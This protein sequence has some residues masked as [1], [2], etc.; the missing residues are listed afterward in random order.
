MSPVIGTHRQK[1]EKMKR[2]QCH[3]GF[4]STSNNRRTFPY[5]VRVHFTIYS[6]TSRHTYLWTWV[7][8]ETIQKFDSKMFGCAY[9]TRREEFA[10]IEKCIEIHF[11]SNEMEGKSDS[12]RISN[13]YTTI[14]FSEF[15]LLFTQME[16]AP[17]PKSSSTH[18]VQHSHH[19]RIIPYTTYN[20]R[21]RHGHN[22][23]TNTGA[24]QASANTETS[25]HKDRCQVIITITEQWTSVGKLFGCCA[26]FYFALTS[27]Y[28]SYSHICSCFRSRRNGRRK[29]RL[30]ICDVDRAFQFEN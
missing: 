30:R 18:S 25:Q 22:A 11:D 21:M 3:D 7:E 14:A 16:V 5:R 13:T 17:M 20:I 19:N 24:P 29:K 10:I 27:L 28:H 26:F 4:S 1:K 9:R 6:T 23:Q 15:R 2:K 12:I 8:M